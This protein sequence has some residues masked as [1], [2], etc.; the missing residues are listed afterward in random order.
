MTIPA[1]TLEERIGYQ[2]HVRAWGAI[3]D[4]I[5]VT[6]GAI[7]ASDNTFT[8]AS[9]GFGTDRVGQFIYVAGAGAAG[10]A[11]ITTIASVTSPT[12]VELT[13]AASTTVAGAVA[14]WGRDNTASLQAAINECASHGVLL[15]VHFGEYL[16]GPLTIPSDSHLI[17]SGEG[18]S[19]LRAI[20]GS[21][22]T[23]T[24][25]IANSDQTG[26]N[27]NI[28]IEQ[29]G[30]DGSKALLTVTGVDILE[31]ANVT[32]ISILRSHFQNAQRVCIRGN[33]WTDATIQG[34]SFVNW[35]PANVTASPDP[36]GAGGAVQCATSSHG[37]SNGINILSNRFDG[38][39][40]K[41]TCLKLSG[42][43]TN[44]IRNVIID[45]NLCLVGAYTAAVLATLGIEL[46]CPSD[47]S[48]GYEQFTI[49]NNIVQGEAGITAAAMF[50][51]S[52]AGSGGL[53]GAVTGNVVRYCYNFGIEI[54]SSSYVSITGNSLTDSSGIILDSNQG[55]GCHHC[56]VTGN[57][58]RKPM[59]FDGGTANPY[60]IK[61]YAGQIQGPSPHTV[62]HCVISGNTVD[63]TGAGS[64]FP[65]GII[66]QS[67]HIDSKV[68]HIQV[69]GNNILGDGTVTQ[70]GILMANSLGAVDR[71]YVSGN[72]LKNVTQ[73]IH[74]GSGTSENNRYFCN[75]FS[76]D[77]TNNYS[78]VLGVGDDIVDVNAEGATFSP[79]SLQIRGSPNPEIDN[80]GN[81]RLTNPNARAY[82]GSGPAD[83]TANNP[84]LVVLN[85][86]N[87][88]SAVQ[89]GIISVNSVFDGDPNWEKSTADAYSR[90]LF[91]IL[92]AGRF[93]V[94]FDD[95][96]NANGAAVGYPYALFVDDST[97]EV[98]T[99][100]PYPI[101]PMDKQSGV[102]AH[103]ASPEG[104][105][106][107]NEGS[108]CIAK[109]AA[110]GHL[111][112]KS[113]GTSNTGW[114]EILTSGGVTDLGD[115]ADVDGTGLT[116]GKQLQWD[117]SKVVNATAGDFDSLDVGG[118]DMTVDA[119]GNTDVNSL[120]VQGTAR[121]D[122]TGRFFPV[123]TSQSAEP[124]LQNGE[125]RIWI[126]TDTGISHVVFRSSG[127][128]QQKVALA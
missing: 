74:T 55:N 8:S 13:D 14:L 1:A 97:S 52:L 58:I 30:F 63:L 61:L 122:S 127:G 41:S 80:L 39:V 88:G 64:D 42:S 96:D 60:G 111:F 69:T 78:G 68:N 36:E 51:I 105:I 123:A 45:G 101:F 25:W 94:G 32:N 3:P 4:L 16:T 54:G 7:T 89:G 47:D 128:V 81:I 59:I 115:A 46:W 91:L 22:P 71:N 87:Y 49:S 43:A 90:A 109:Y 65:I 95:A 56:T 67:N 120:D 112:L 83:K 118:G 107:A 99:G 108:I 98:R 70:R 15:R 17:G 48:P 104:V 29:M 33:R 82:I 5:E 116:T 23:D 2:P 31:I 124:T 19:K 75:F 35:Q 85:K 76:D 10:V 110:S 37:E 21:I 126:D 103:N 24:P 100:A 20:P 73:G 92:G 119:S 44:P 86:I 117:G 40:S 9:G 102:Y 72:L 66:L 38:T 121:L 125:L 57:T 62:T 93:A 27:Q 106:T 26:G 77:V 79:T 11:L 84:N 28:I 50:G 114:V 113:T 53:Y 12:E 34:C 18:V 6:D